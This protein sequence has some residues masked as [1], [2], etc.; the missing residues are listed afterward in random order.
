MPVHPAPGG[1]RID[2]HV[3]PRAS[4]TEVA[5]LHGDALKLRIASPPVDGA[6]NDEI[7]RFLAEQLGVARRAVTITA[8]ASGRRKAVTVEGITVDAARRALRLD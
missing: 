5:G 7:V 6:A 4:R 1:V 8:G 2:L 3:Q